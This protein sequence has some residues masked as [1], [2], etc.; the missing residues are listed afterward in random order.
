M[1]N[2]FVVTVVI[3]THWAASVGGVSNS[4]FSGAYLA[5]RRINPPSGRWLFDMLNASAIAGWANCLNYDL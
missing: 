2:P 4:P 5:L 3:A 1:Y